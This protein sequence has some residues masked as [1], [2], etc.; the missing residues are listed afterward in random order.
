[1][2]EYLYFVPPTPETNHKLG[3]KAVRMQITMLLFL[4]Q[5]IINKRTDFL[6]KKKSY[7]LPSVWQAKYIVHVLW[8]RWAMHSWHSLRLVY[9]TDCYVVFK[10]W[11]TFSIFENT[12]SG[13]Y[14][15]KLSD[16]YFHIVTHMFGSFSRSKIKLF[17]F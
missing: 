14:T 8:F 1:M 12:S 6:I 17:L 16:W 2:F 13:Y 15:W 4:S 9:T 5:S 11:F 10:Y 7:L 3:W